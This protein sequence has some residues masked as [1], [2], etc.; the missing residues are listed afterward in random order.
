MHA[1]SEMQV[2]RSFCECCRLIMANSSSV[3]VFSIVFF[4]ATNSV[5]LLVCLLAAILVFRLK[6]H[7]KVVYRLALYQVLAAL[8]F[9]TVEVLEIVFITDTNDIGNS[10]NVH[11]SKYSSGCNAIGWLV[12]Y[13]QW[14][15]LLFTMWVT[16]HLFCFVVFYKNM[17][18]LE[19][20]Y[21]VTSLLV[22]A[23]I[24]CV[25]L[26]T[27]SYAI[28][29]NRRC[30][31]DHHE[32]VERTV[33]WNVPAMIILLASSIAM[34]VMV[35]KLLHK[36]CGWR[37]QYEVLTDR[38]QFWMAFKQLIP[39]AAYPILF[40]VFILP[41]VIMDVIDAH[42]STIPV[43]TV[44]ISNALFTS[45]WSLTS[46]ATLIVHVTLAR[47]VEIKKRRKSSSI[48]LRYQHQERQLLQ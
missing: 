19:V 12:V 32:L 26:I 24:A 38:N 48:Q 16:F 41:V 37:S 21:V 3:N 46:G 2:T 9:A 33:L 10:S 17:K 28:S 29:I 13:T 36:V 45:L 43:E 27:R 47:C 14:M 39:L 22:P 34:V 15:K 23:V 18:K 30:Y 20:L 44:S 4:T 5:S 40:L 25:P 6:L 35:T 8:A 11:N 42:S 31:I 1:R 7:T